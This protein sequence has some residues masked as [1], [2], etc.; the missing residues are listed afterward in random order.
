[1][2]LNKIYRLEVQLPAEGSQPGD[3]L[4]IQP[5]ITI[6][7]GIDRRRFASANRMDLKIYNLSEQ[8]RSRIFRDR[9]NRYNPTQPI[10]DTNHPRY[11]RLYGGYEHDGLNLS[12]MFNGALSY[13]FSHSR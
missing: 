8:T 13:A 3:F 12:L 9:F 11:V 6:E 2:K 4:V 1:M 10:S 5:P 7:F